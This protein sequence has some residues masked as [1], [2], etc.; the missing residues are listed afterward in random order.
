MFF[1]ACMS[2]VSGYQIERSA[3]NTTRGSGAD[4]AEWTDH[5]ITQ[6]RDYT[7]CSTRQPKSTEAQDVFLTITR[8]ETRAT[9]PGNVSRCHSDTSGKNA[10]Q[11]G[12]SDIGQVDLR[13]LCLW[14]LFPLFLQNFEFVLNLLKRTLFHFFSESAIGH[15]R[16]IANGVASVLSADGC[17]H[18]W[19]VSLC[20]VPPSSRGS[21]TFQPP[22]PRGPRQLYVIRHGERVD[23]TF[24]KDWIQMS[25][26]QA[27]QS[28]INLSQIL[29]RSVHQNAL[30]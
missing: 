20:R 1:R 3:K 23:F 18:S 27:G 2:F 19:V 7:R 10:T 24:G 21:E 13:F 15:W 22:R 9:T 6:H 11:R 5:R 8:D 26:D 30:V 17:R 29:E 25:F 16:C 14:E 4:S 12:P 28:S